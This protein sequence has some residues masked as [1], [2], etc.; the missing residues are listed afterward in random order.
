MATK[1]KV[2][3]I[4]GNGSLNEEIIKMITN[5]NEKKTDIQL[6]LIMYFC[7]AKVAIYPIVYT[8]V[9]CSIDN[10]TRTIS[11]LENGKPTL[12]I[13]EIEVEPLVIQPDSSLEAEI[14]EEAE[15]NDLKGVNI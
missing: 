14:R 2:T 4:H 9:Q 7:M 8:D 10:K 3:D 5:H 13:Q 12:T 1:F 11:I 15:T 6:E